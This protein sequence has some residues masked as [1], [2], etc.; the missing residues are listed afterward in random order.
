[1]APVIRDE[2]IH[3]VVGEN[4]AIQ[5]DRCGEQELETVL[6][7]DVAIFHAI[8]LNVGTVSGGE[9]GSCTVHHVEEDIDRLVGD[10]GVVVQ[11]SLK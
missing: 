5:R 8:S 10:M 11:V 1:M 9:L 3:V 7:G 6:G 2:F 4:L